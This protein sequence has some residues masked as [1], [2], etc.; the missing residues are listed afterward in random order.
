[1]AL[2]DIRPKAG[3]DPR[4][5]KHLPARF[6]DYTGTD[7]GRAPGRKQAGCTLG[8][9]AEGAHPPSPASPKTAALGPHR[10]PHP[11]R[12]APPP[13]GCTRRH[14]HP[15]KK[16]IEAAGPGP[17]PGARKPRDAANPAERLGCPPRAPGAAHPGPNLAP[18]PGSPSRCRSPLAPPR[19]PRA[20]PADVTAR[21]RGP[22]PIKGAA[23][24][25]TAGLCARVCRSVPRT[26]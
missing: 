17:C 23:G 12:P 21:G 4:S 20:P 1:M 25:A 24:G 18:R 13:G 6:S 16:E 2:D 5:G 8:G 22:P 10:D 7:V 26:A 15:E 19:R 9:K 14:S 11:P 3:N